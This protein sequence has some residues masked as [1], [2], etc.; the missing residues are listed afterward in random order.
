MVKVASCDRCGN[1]SSAHWGSVPEC[2]KCGSDVKEV[3]VDLEGRERIPR[4]LNWAGVGLL[5][6]VTLLFIS[7]M[8]GVLE[9]PMWALLILVGTCIVLLFGSIVYQQALVKESI[10]K[11]PAQIGRSRMQRRVRSPMARQ[12][13]KEK[14]RSNLPVK[15]PIRKGPLPPEKPRKATKILQNR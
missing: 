1:V 14:A 5:G 6:A 11:A 13:P 9:V 3:E 4:Y 15:R 8:A 7:T 12:E 10:E 2:P